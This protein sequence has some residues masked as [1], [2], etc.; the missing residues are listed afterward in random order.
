MD[1][2]VPQPV[3]ARIRAARVGEGGAKL[4]AIRLLNYATNHVVCH[5]PSYGLRHAWYRRVLG[6]RLGHNSGIHLNCYI[7]F[8]GPSRLRKDHY[9]TIGDHTR[10]N[11]SCL[12]DARGPLSIGDNV[13]VS[14]EV[15]IVTTQHR[16]ED[17]NFGVESRAVV[18]EDHVWIG[19]RA[20]I[21]PGVTVGRGAVV[22]AGAV[23]TKDVPP[24]AVV[25][26]VP[27]KLIGTRGL[28]NPSYVLADPFPM[29]E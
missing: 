20:M 27:A 21:M 28:D 5:L 14:A 7:W 29:F 8:F 12:L 26:G 17:P 18:I 23:V 22:A 25:G 11:R 2:P 13:S 19:M 4:A 10:I 24:L 1:A 3:E 9:L 15:A 16:P 6:V